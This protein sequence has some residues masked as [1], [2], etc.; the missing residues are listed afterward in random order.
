MAGRPGEVS[1]NDILVVIREG[2]GPVL[3]SGEIGEKL[4]VV[5]KTVEKRLRKLNENGIIDGKQI[6]DSYAWWITDR[7]EAKVND[8]KI[9]YLNSFLTYR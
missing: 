6:G 1:D 2:S 7:G 8:G 5:Q 4:P 3:S 9:L